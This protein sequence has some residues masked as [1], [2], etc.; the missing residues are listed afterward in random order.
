MKPSF[1]SAFALLFLVVK[2]V[3]QQPA[4]SNMSGDSVLKAVTISELEKRMIQHGLSNVKKHIP[5]AILDIRYATEN[6]FLRK[7]VYGDFS[8]CYLQPDVVKKLKMADSL[9]KI[10]KPGWKL[11]L[12]DC[13]RPISVQKKMW[14]ALE[15]PASEKGKYVSNPANHSVHNYGAAVDLALADENGNYADMGTE[16][17]FFGELAYPF[18]ESTFVK[19]GKLTSGQVANRQLLREVMKKAGFSGVPHEWWHFNACSRE[20]AKKRYR[21][22]E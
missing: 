11:V 5:D 20:T 21:A 16:F 10:N 12:Y 2:P 15:M 6:N 13:A 7:N 18:M 14:D 9:L 4:L 3:A 19:S 1:L 22:V 17:D 8:S